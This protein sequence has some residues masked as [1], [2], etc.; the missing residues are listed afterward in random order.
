MVT[1]QMLDYACALISTMTQSEVKA[2]WPHLHKVIK[3]VDSGRLQSCTPHDL[4]PLDPVALHEY[5]EAERFNA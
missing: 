5:E 2:K 4:V 1:C 3:C